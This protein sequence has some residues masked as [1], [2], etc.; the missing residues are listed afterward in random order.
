MKQTTALSPR[1]LFRDTPASVP[2]ARPGVDS[3]GVKPI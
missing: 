3:Y 2:V 1:T